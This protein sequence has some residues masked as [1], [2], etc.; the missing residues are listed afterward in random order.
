M[1]ENHADPNSLDNDGNSFLSLAIYHEKLEIIKYAAESYPNLMALKNKKGLS[2]IHIAAE[3]GNIEVL[4]Y[5]RS[6][7]PNIDEESEHGTPLEYA[8]VWKK[9]DMFL[10]LLALG[11]NP[12]GSQGKNIP[13]PLVI[14]ASM[15]Y[16]E[17]VHALVNANCNINLPDKD[18]CTAL[19]VAS[20]FDFRDLFEFLLERRAT[21]NGRTILAAYKNNKTEIVDRLLPLTSVDDIVIE[22]LSQINPEIAEE[23]K[24]QGNE[25]F[26]AKEYGKAIEFYTKA[27]ANNHKSIYFSNRSQAYISNFEPK[28]AILD[29]KI[30]RI[31]DPN[32]FKAYLREGQALDSLDQKRDAAACIWQALKIT[33]DKT[34]QKVFVSTLNEIN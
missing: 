21:V 28:E 32:N 11:A 3:T 26:A 12:N 25:A 16:T 18:G 33:K 7:H 10:H 13:P 20:E 6:I 24:I 34:I 31:L 23:F 8:L 22:P 30:A 2:P 9:T 14:A 27:I 4:E 19:E 1:I 5:L 15:N 29:A 17:A